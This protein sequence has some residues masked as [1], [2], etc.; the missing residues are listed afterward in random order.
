MAT[1]ALIWE[2]G[3]DLGHI[4]RFSI[5][6]RELAARGHRPVA[7]VRDAAGMREA[8][9]SDALTFLPAPLWLAAPGG[10]P[11]ELNFTE[12]LYRNGF[13]QPLR[14]ASVAEAW[15]NLYAL[16]RPDL[17]I[18]DF[19]PIAQLAARG[20]GLPQVLLSS[21]FAVPPQARPFPSYRFWLKEKNMDARL[22]ETEERCTRNTNRALAALKAPAIGA[23]HELFAAGEVLLCERPEFDVYGARDGVS[24]VHCIND[25]ALGVAPHWPPAPG[26]KVFAYLKPRFEHFDSLLELLGKLEASVLVFAPGCA[27]ATVR[28]FSSHRLAFC[29]EPLQLGRVAQECDYALCHGGTGTA[30]VFADQGKPVFLIPL[31]VEQMMFSQRMLAQG[32]AAC[33]PLGGQALLLKRELT[34]FFEQR[35]LPQQARDWAAARP[36]LP[37]AER[38]R[39]VCDRLEARLGG[40][41]G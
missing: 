7:V 39:Q 29:E 15:R 27:P 23:M 19:A 30:N 5:V 35:R 33:L 8:L 31:Q 36:A 32:I 41:G 10:L 16:I 2:L 25:D 37:M 22:Q 24:Y 40:A 3:A 20:L 18:L 11:P 1:F 17:L 38:V 4:T 21:S 12:T 34:Q 13:L 9:G 28:R 14:L 26:P 6:A